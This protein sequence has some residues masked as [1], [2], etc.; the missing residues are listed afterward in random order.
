MLFRSLYTNA[1][2]HGV[3]GLDSELKRDALGFAQYY[4]E[5]N[6]HLASLEEGYVRLHL[7]IVPRGQGGHL[8]IRVE[9]SGAGFDVDRVLA[10]SAQTHELSGRGLNLIRELSEHSYWSQDGRTA[11]VEFSWGALA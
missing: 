9:D 6:E 10:L 11:C 7:Q 5:R 1:L 3:L 4:R 8:T 2:E